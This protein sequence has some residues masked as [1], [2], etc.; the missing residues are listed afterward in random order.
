MGQALAA[1]AGP[2]S[3]PSHGRHVAHALQPERDWDEGRRGSASTQDASVVATAPERG[4][5]R[6]LT[7]EGDS[8]MPGTTPSYADMRGSVSFSLVRGT[9]PT[10]EAI[11][12]GRG[13]AAGG[14][15][16]WW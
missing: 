1:R 3:R 10:A 8:C 11:D 4:V 9:L 12:G 6:A 5:G 7:H 15:C 2:D 14:C 13:Q 16:L